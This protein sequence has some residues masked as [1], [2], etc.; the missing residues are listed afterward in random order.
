MIEHPFLEALSALWARF[1]LGLSTFGVTLLISANS[2]FAKVRMSHDNGYVLRGRLRIAADARV[3]EHDFFVQGR[4]FACRVRHGAASFKDDAK[5]VVRSAS[6]K[7]AD[8]RGRSPLDILMNTGRMPLFWNAR[9][10]MQFMRRSIQGKGKHYVSYLQQHPQAAIGGGDSVRRDPDTPHRLVYWTQTTSGFIGLDQVFRYVRYR[11]V[12]VP[13]DGTETGMPDDWDRHH[14]WLQN[15]LPDETRGRNYLKDAVRET[16]ESGQV[17]R[18]RLQ[19]QLRLPPPDE[20]V[21]PEWI[22]ASVLWDETMFPW[23]D[24]ADLELVEMLSHKESMLTWF[25]L[26]HHPASLPIPK[27]RSIDDAHS[28]N[29]LRLAGIWATR[30][31]LL[32]YALT[33]VPKPYP[34]SRQAKDWIGVPPMANP[35]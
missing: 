33:G 3:P 10:F 6:I 1:V 21:Q 4:S 19:I 8:R 26:C 7:F 17:M 25:D 22:S 5:L 9:T 30:A 20:K 14:A 11:L 2:L 15:P 12:P 27:A 34:D 16:V 32:S 28:L 18:Y 13:F 24:L 29:H 31:R 35:P 23:L